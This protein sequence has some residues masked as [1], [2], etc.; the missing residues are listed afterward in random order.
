MFLYP[1]LSQ[2]RRGAVTIIDVQKQNELEVGEPRFNPSPNG[3][4]HISAPFNLSF[5]S[6]TL[7]GS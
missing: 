4:Y 2:K 7:Y 6:G 5:P 3:Q 1:A